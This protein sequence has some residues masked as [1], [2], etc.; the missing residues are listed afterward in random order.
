[1]AALLESAEPGRGT[2]LAIVRLLDLAWRGDAPGARALIDE[3]V[4]RMLI[5]GAPLYVE[6]YPRAQPA[7][8]RT[9]SAAR[10]FVA[11]PGEAQRTALFRAA[12]NSYPFGPGDGCFA[13]SELGTHGTPGA[14]CA[15]GVGCLAYLAP[16]PASRR[17]VDLWRA[18]VL[19]WLSSP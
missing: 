14:G 4:C 9:L 16:A 10:A 18:A 8:E 5:A 1:M 11:T 2:V 17:L 13:V 3:A 7:A 6:A 12:T 15:G 19:P